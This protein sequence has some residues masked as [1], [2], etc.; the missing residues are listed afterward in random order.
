LYINAFYYEYAFYYDL[1][2][3]CMFIQNKY[4]TW[5][6]KIILN[7]RNRII[8][9]YVEKH[10]VIPK[11][12]GGTD[13]ISNL[14]V[15][16]A[17]EHFVC[18]LLLTKMTEG[19]H[20]RSMWHA[21]WNMA[22]QKRQY[23]DRYK[24]SSRVYEII[25]TANAKAL[26]ESNR[27]KSSKNKGRI[28]SAEWRAKL[29]EANKGKLRSEES[30]AKQSATITGRTRPARSAEWTANQRLTIAHNRLDCEVCGKNI[31]KSAYTRSHGSKCKG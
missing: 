23:Q 16:T 17:K 2:N 9:G 10:H 22:N 30:R 21:A 1:I 18:H 7:A 4:T 5:Y 3:K 24:V 27:G 19:L 26:S 25:K 11:S 28:I 29:S 31:T 12:L 15:L 6:N 13:E 20:R 14:V 8:D